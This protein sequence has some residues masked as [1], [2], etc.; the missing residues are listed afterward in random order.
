M[1]DTRK[2]N[3]FDGDTE[4]VY[5]GPFDSAEEANNVIDLYDEKFYVGLERSK[6]AQVWAEAVAGGLVGVGRN[7]DL[8]EPDALQ[9]ALE[10][11]MGEYFRPGHDTWR[12]NTEDLTATVL[13]I[14][15]EYRS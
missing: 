8:P 7:G 3:I 12:L 14:I 2:Y 1:S 15:F 5:A 9:K 13:S 11:H 4:K 6:T 10:R